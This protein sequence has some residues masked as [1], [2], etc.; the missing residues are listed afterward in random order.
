MKSLI[1]R[2][3]AR[4]LLPVMLLSSVVV[5]LR[6]HNDPG[7][8]FVGGLIAAAAF[9]LHSMAYGSA[10]VR[11]LLTIGRFKIDLHTT[12]GVGLLLAFCSS[13]PGLVIGL[14]GGLPA[15]T[16]ML[17][18]A[19]HAGGYE[20]T[21]FSGLWWGFVVPGLGEIKLGTPMFFDIGV[22]ITVQCVTLLMILTLE[23]A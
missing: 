16:T 8:G 5:C 7:G 20:A 12:I 19:A 11:E 23:E 3:A 2:T 21:A 1:F 15:D 10:S 14:V 22:Y 6:G 17:G 13:L 18:N 4:F 9:G